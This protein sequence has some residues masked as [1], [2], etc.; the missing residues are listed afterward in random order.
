MAGTRP[1]VPVNTGGSTVQP[2]LPIPAVIPVPAIKIPTF[3]DFAPGKT[4]GITENFF[5]SPAISRWGL[6]SGKIPW[7]PTFPDVVPAAPTPTANL[8]AF[9]FVQLLTV[10]TPPLSWLSRYPDFVLRAPQ[11]IDSGLSYTPAVSKWGLNPGLGW[12]PTFPDS[13]RTSQPL[14]A[15]GAFSYVP[16][17]S[18]WGTGLESWK[19]V[20]SD[21]VP[22][23]PRPVDA[24]F[25]A[26]LDISLI[27]S[28][29]WR[30]HFADQVPGPSRPVDT[31]LVSYVPAT[32]KWGTSVLA[33]QPTYPD[34]ARTAPRAV[35]EGFFA[36]V[37]QSQTQREYWHPSYPDLAPSSPR[38]VDTGI[39]SYVPAINRWG[40]NAD[41][42]WLPTFPDRVLGPQPTLPEGY[43]SYVTAISKWGTNLLS[44][45]PVYPSSALGLASPVAN[46]SGFSFVNES[47]TQNHFWR[48]FYSDLVP[49]APRAVDTGFFAF[50]PLP[51]T[52]LAPVLS[53]LPT[54]PDR[55]PGAPRPVDTGL[56]SYVN[57]NIFSKLEWMP[58]YPDRATGL[59]TPVPEG[60]LAYVPALSRWGIDSG[61]IPWKPA[62]PDLAL[63][64]PNPVANLGLVAF[65]NQNVNQNHS[66]HP[67]FPDFATGPTLPPAFGFIAY[68]PAISKWGQL[69]W[70]PIFPVQ[71][72]AAPRSPEGAIGY[73]PALRQW[74]TGLLSWQP[75]YP[76]QIATPPRPVDTGLVA[77]TPAINRWGIDGGKIPWRPVFP[78][79]VPARVNPVGNLGG[80]T[81][82][83]NESVA[84]IPFV[85]SWLPDAPALYLSQPRALDT[86]LI[87]YVPAL[88]RW[89]IDGGKIPWSSVYPDRV[90]GVARAV[91]EGRFSFV[92]RDL[93]SKQSW[94]P[95]YPDRVPGLPRPVDTGI[96]SY[97]PAI[98]KWGTG[99]L[100]WLPSYPSQIWV[101]PQVQEGQFSF[102]NAS[103]V[104][105]QNW[106]PVFPDFIQAAPR[107]VGEGFIAYTPALNKWGQMS[108]LP[109]Y[110]ER[111]QANPFNVSIYDQG[112]Y[113]FTNENLF[114]REL[115]FPTYPNRID[116]S[117]RAVDE[118]FFAYTPAVSN[119]GIDG[120]KTPWI[121]IYPN[122]ILVPQVPVAEGQFSFVRL[123]ISTIINY[124]FPVYPSQMLIPA[125]PVAV[126]SFAWLFFSNS[127]PIPGLYALLSAQVTSKAVL[128]VAAAPYSREVV[129]DPFAKTGV[130]VQASAKLTLIS[131]SSELNVT[132]PESETVV[133]AGPSAE[134]EV[135]VTPHAILTTE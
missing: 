75:S 76:V 99:L 104:Q 43:V 65:I 9:S 88:N 17:I 33:W 12:L 59:P 86:G 67:T 134:L 53:W 50:N 63:G 118:G 72:P 78:D 23:L 84:P 22:G 20:F 112:T 73:Q 80:S 7:K 129:Q 133:S 115:W 101:T 45:S 6:D 82:V 58:S 89:G 105:R 122:Q 3:P 74:G 85:S 120:G 123:I 62:F 5:Y 102:V 124:W 117:A 81:L 29:Y 83:Q 27:K 13:V 79:L 111:I 68:T 42:S 114:S 94:R 93:F 61:K 36:F 108:W 130:A 60:T 21:L 38:P 15:E 132:A 54:Y 30:P 2:I 64:P 14:V 44:W 97:V 110:P 119:W 39:I 48:P 51:I 91:D 107:P 113:V 103:L 25:I 126:G 95:T 41:L 18:K 10:S 109:V 131:Y 56:I 90:W 66:W 37:N 125:Q 8:G 16:A 40:L 57:E 69:S 77:Y 127:P 70:L 52:T 128:T 34:F 24:G 71:V 31:G 100:S 116:A 47:I 28:Q 92:D 55:V 87:S 96:V 4:P 49:G 19:P 46:L 106:H 35:D 1:P 11:P 121:S 98:N 135:D 32:S 26:Y